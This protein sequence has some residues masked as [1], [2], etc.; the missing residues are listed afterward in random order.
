MATAKIKVPLNSLDCPI[1]LDTVGDPKILPCG[2]SLCGPK[3]L[4]NCLY[5]LE[6]TFHSIKC[7]SCQITHS[8]QAADVPTN[9]SLR[10]MLESYEPVKDAKLCT[11]HG[12][13]IIAVCKTDAAQICMKCVKNHAGHDIRDIE[14]EAFEKMSL[15]W[16][17]QSDKLD[18]MVKTYAECKESI[19]D[20]ISYLEESYLKI[21]SLQTKL[22]QVI[23]KKVEISCKLVEHKFNPNDEDVLMLEEFLEL[24]DNTDEVSQIGK[25]LATF[26][27]EVDSAKSTELTVGN[28]LVSK[29]PQSTVLALGKFGGEKIVG[30]RGEKAT[31]WNDENKKRDFGYGFQAVCHKNKL[32]MIGGETNDYIATTRVSDLYKNR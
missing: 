20:S 2:H 12:K 15:F 21:N 17:N 16:K 28:P 5:K 13:E 22:V 10:E 9:F 24:K 11:K 27:K 30:G 32:Y 23:A 25:L 31:N 14:E 1:C 19:K 29:I 6:E 18:D 26:F 7:S 4:N 8:V 3:S